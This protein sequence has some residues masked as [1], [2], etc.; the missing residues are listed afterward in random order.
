MIRKEE[1]LQLHKTLGLP[2]ATIEKDYVLSLIIWGIASHQEL[3]QTWV[4]KGGT[5]LKKCFFGEYRF[6]EDLDYTLTK[7]ASINPEAIILYLSQSFE[8]IYER[9]GLRIDTRDVSTSPFPD[10]NGLVLQIKVPYQG[11]LL[12][13]GSLPK[14]KLD[15]SQDEIIV[16]IPEKRELIHAYSDTSY[17]DT[18]ILCYSIYEIFAEKLRALKERTRPR[19]IYDIV[20]LGH[21]FFKNNSNILKLQQIAVEKFKHKNLIFPEC[22]ASISNI[23]VQEAKTDWQNMLAHQ[24]IPLDPFDQTWERA[25]EVIKLITLET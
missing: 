22:L 9:F 20:H 12:S 4:F 10:K 3:G 18:N 23:A 8:M 11:P 15:L 2:L 14:I 7:Q 5:A 19:D 21:Y 13:S 6:S 17:L 25:L 1:L 16:D 24:I